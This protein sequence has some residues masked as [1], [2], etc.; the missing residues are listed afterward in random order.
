MD[1]HACCEVMRVLLIVVDL[2]HDG[3]AWG[4]P[5]SLLNCF[6][7][8]DHFRDPCYN[9]LYTLHCLELAK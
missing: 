2:S 6:R 3:I 7:L 4:N 1:E 5:S 8:F 9:D